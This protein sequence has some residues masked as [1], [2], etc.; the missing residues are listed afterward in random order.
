MQQQTQDRME[1]C[2]GAF[3]QSISKIRTGRAHP[4]LLEG[5]VVDYYGSRTPLCQLANIT[6]EDSR[7]LVITLYDRDMVS[8]VEKAILIT[9]LGLNPLSAGSVLR[10]HLPPLTEERRKALIKQVRAEAEQSRV[11]VRTAR[12]GANDALKAQLKEKLLSEDQE[13]HT[14]TAIQKL[15]DSM[16]KKIDEILQQKEHELLKI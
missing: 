16:V 10:I 14:Q 1:S 9:N 4:S 15:T 5:V 6:A 7:T 12:R 8:A 2:I 13:H 3:Q 11:A